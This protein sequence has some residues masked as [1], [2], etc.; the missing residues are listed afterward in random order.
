[1][2][3]IGALARLSAT[4]SPA[5]AFLARCSSGGL[6]RRL[7]VVV[8]STCK[9]DWFGEVCPERRGGELH[10]GSRGERGRQGRR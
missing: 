7:V 8:D 2:S 9:V 1:M 4:V 5:A 6:G 3:T 10:G